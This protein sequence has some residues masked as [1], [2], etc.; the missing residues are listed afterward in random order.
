M[1]R[2]EE[3]EGKEEEGEVRKELNEESKLARKV[4]SVVSVS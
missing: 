4:E 3:E 2:D 1:R